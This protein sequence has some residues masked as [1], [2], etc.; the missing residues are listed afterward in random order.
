MPFLRKRVQELLGYQAFMVR[1]VDD[2]MPSAQ[3]FEKPTATEG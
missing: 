3:V 1:A 2:Y